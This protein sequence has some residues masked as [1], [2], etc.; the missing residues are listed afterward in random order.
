MKYNDV[1][2]ECLWKLTL[3]KTNGLCLLLYSPSESF[4][5]RLMPLEFRTCVRE[6]HET[7][8]PDL[9]SQLDLEA[10]KEQ[11]ELDGAFLVGKALFLPS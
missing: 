10:V 2:P 7:L 5:M 8:G 4:K 3:G 1:I 6:F 11:L 9:W